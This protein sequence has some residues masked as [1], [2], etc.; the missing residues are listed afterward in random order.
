MKDMSC[1]KGIIVSLESLGITLRRNSWKNVSLKDIK[2]IL[3]F[4][5]DIEKTAEIER[6][7]RILVDKMTEIIKG[8]KGSNLHDFVT[9]SKKDNHESHKSL[10][11]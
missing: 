3:T 10:L 1:K 7:N 4:I 2:Y 11:I 6:Q 5:I 9:N 8:K